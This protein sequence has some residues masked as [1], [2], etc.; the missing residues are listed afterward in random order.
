M[1]EEDEE[2]DDDENI[3]NLRSIKFCSYGETKVRISLQDTA[4][5]IERPVDVVLWGVDSP[6]RASEEAVFTRSREI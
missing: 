4:L 2:E 6:S 5:A 3:G 1:T